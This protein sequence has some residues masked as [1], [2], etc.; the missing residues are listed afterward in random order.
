VADALPLLYSDLADWY[1]LL[2]AAEDYAEEAEFYFR[3]LT[4]VGGA[5]PGSLLELGAGAGNNAWHY[6]RAIAR[7]TL[8]DLSP[9][10]LGLSA[11]QNPECEHIV[12]D[13]RTV[14]LGREFDVVFV[15]DA[16]SYLTTESDLRQALETA[17][18]HCR[19]GGVALFAPDATRENFVAET[20]HGGHDGDDGRALRYL[21]WTFDPDP[22]DNTY[23]T[24]Y[25]YLLHTNGEPPRTL[26]DRH[27]MGLFGA[28]DWL[29]LLADVG[30]RAET[31]PFFHSE[32]ERPLHVFVGVRP[33]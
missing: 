24:D 20:D 19:R 30:F 2:T 15:H 5:P 3:T 7:V 22:S 1:L 28:A 13:M 26:F 29:R 33:A 4:E 31:R 25:A 27:E 16:I 6:K 21:E 11:T 8:T 17:F 10:M 9:R 12:G 32:V 14:R 18:I 23:L